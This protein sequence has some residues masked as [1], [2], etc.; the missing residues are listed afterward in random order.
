MSYRKPIDVEKYIYWGDD[1]SMEVEVIGHFRLLLCIGFY[2]DL[3]DTF[4]ILSFRRNLIS[5]SYLDKSGYSC[6]FGNNQVNLYLNSKVTG[7]GSLVV[8][9]NISMLDIVA[10]YHEN[11]NIESCGAKRKLDNAHSRALWHKRLGHISRNRVERL[12][13]GGT[14]DSVD[15][16]DLNV[17]VECIKGKQTKQKKLSA[18]RATDVLELIHTNICGPFPTPSWNAQQYFVS[19]IDDHS[20]YAYLFLIHEK[21]QVLDVFK[22]FKVKVENQLNKRIKNV[23][24]DNGG[25]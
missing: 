12:V 2:L 13:S 17:C 23:K 20:R 19:F 18:Y 1:K 5:V 11:L 24:S 10:S 15:F 6:S 21:S 22:S 8:Y 9:D 7:T 16:T 4:S 14:R 25:E 3:K